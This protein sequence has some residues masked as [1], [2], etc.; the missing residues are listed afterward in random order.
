MPREDKISVSCKDFSLNVI[1]SEKNDVLHACIICI[2]K[3]CNY[4]Y[5]SLLHDFLFFG[6]LLFVCYIATYKDFLL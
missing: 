5:L 2:F 4:N 1:E 6:F 3:V